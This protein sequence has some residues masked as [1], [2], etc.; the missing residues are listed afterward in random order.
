MILSTAYALILGL[1]SFQAESQ[2][3]MPDAVIRPASPV[4]LA[5]GDA[6]GMALMES[7]RHAMPPLLASR[8]AIASLPVVAWA[9]MPDERH[10]AFGH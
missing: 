3:V 2:T 9:T 5:A 8:L 10:L 6:L 7:N 4:S 1:S